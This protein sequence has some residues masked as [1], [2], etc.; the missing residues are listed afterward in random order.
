MK[1]LYIFILSIALFSLNADSIYLSNNNVVTGTIVSMTEDIVKIDTTN[2]ILEVKK[3]NIVRGEFFGTGEEISGTKLLEF[4]LDGS[5]RDSSGM[6]YPVT[7]K[8]IPYDNGVDGENK[9]ALK[10]NGDG[11]YFFIKE[12]TDL[13]TFDE[14]TIAMYFYPEDTSKNSFLVS[15]WNNTLKDGKA[16]GRFSL[17]VMKT[18]LAFYIVD[19]QGYYQSVSIKDKL[20]LMEW[21]AIAIRYKEGE[22]SI[23]INGETAVS[24]KVPREGLLEGD[25]PIYFMTAKYRDDYKYYNLKG[26]LDKITMW[27]SS[28]SDKELNLLYKL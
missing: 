8:S 24:N 6:G 28:L 23:Y 13:T 16:N 5:I 15:C 11:Q 3:E 20:K 10:S 17:S 21:N 14:F 26:K 18:S 25:W 7:T 22:M 19:A 9:G 1:V 2:G 12:G 4:L 27:D